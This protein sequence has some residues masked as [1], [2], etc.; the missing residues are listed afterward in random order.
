MR[1]KDYSLGRQCG[2]SKPIFNRSKTG[3]CQPCFLAKLTA[4]PTR[5]ARIAA[6]QKRYHA[7]PKNKYALKRRAMQAGKTR[8]AN[9]IWRE[10]TVKRM[11]EIVQPLSMTPESLASRNTAELLLK[12][13]ESRLSWCPHDYRAHYYLIRG[14]R[15]SAADA[16]AMIEAQMKADIAKLTPFERQERAMAQGAKLIANDT[17]PSPYAAQAKWSVG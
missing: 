5:N 9:P 10:A 4:D 7:D 11:R 15:V 2:C 8:R 3:L 1:V 16:R 13:V 17:A 14:K 12:S 6:S